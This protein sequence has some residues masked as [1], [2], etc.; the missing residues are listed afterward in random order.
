MPP[1]K[2]SL[3]ARKVLLSARAPRPLADKIT[4]YQ[5]RHGLDRSAAI[6]EL[7]ERGL[8]GVKLR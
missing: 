5:D 4:K 6:V 3:D 7:L 1:A 8:R 2:Q